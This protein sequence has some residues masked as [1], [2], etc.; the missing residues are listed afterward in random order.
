M[1]FKLGS[2]IIL[3]TS[4][5]IFFIALNVLSDR[6]AVFCLRSTHTH[7]HTQTHTHTLCAGS[8]AETL[9]LVINLSNTVPQR[10]LSLSFLQGVKLYYYN[11]L[12]GLK[13]CHLQIDE[14][15][16]LFTNDMGWWVW[17]AWSNVL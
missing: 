8:M 7:T 17:W 15:F 12:H 2:Y 6:H 16:C 1:Y 5:L 11:N 14:D 9:G 13:H 4:V 3:A 10:N